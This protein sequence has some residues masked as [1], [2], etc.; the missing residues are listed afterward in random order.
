MSDHLDHLSRA[1][2]LAIGKR[3]RGCNVILLVMLVALIALFFG[4]S[5]VKLSRPQQHGPTTQ[6][7]I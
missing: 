3:R 1:Q 2:S 4:M 7:P 5:V 6:N